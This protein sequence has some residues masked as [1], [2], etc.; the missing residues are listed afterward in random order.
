MISENETND[1]NGYIENKKDIEILVNGCRTLI[2]INCG[3]KMIDD[4][5]KQLAVD[6]YLMELRHKLYAENKLPSPILR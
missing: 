6:R 4:R 3:H 2:T 5:L 1:M